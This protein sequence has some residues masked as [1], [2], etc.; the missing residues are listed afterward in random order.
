[1]HCYNVLKDILPWMFIYRA[2]VGKVSID[3][4]IGKPVDVMA[5]LSRF[6]SVGEP[7][8]IKESKPLRHPLLSGFESIGER[9]LSN[10]FRRD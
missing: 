8:E 3:N 10:R 5:G 2:L 1:M 7:I 9:V 6:S 4:L